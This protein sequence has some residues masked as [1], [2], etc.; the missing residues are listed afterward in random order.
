M[1][2]SHCKD[3]KEQCIAVKEKWIVLKERDIA[4][5]FGSTIMDD[6]S[7]CCRP[8]KCAS[9]VDKHFK[10]PTVTLL[11]GIITLIPCND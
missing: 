11:E 3:L 5:D 1:L 4:R 6:V 8:R 10:Q 7:S 9:L 2:I